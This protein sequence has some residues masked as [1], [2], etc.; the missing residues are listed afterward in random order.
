MQQDRSTGWRL[1]TN[2]RIQFRYQVIGILMGAIF[3]VLLAKLFM[4][5]YPI[6]RADQ[7]SHPGLAG[8]EQW[9][10]AMTY[11]FVGAL[12]ALTDPKP[13]VMQALAI[14]I[15]IGLVTEILRKVIKSRRAYKKF[16]ASSRRGALTDF[17]LDAI[18]LPSPYASSFG[19]FFDWKTSL[20]YASG[21][22]VSTLYDS[23][24]AKRN[25][26]GSPG[27]GEVS[28]DMS[29]TSLVGGG[30]IAGDSLAALTLGIVG[31]LGTL[32]KSG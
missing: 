16:V 10:A 32:L 9:Q 6:L 3:A 15:G 5:A 4:T 26:H 30:L 22:V 17:F 20:W 13:Y 28:S 25:S 7:L 23:I 24:Y 27:E 11:K 2:R 1:G 29:T 21:G 12:R 18:V 31:L 8:T 19:G 14:G